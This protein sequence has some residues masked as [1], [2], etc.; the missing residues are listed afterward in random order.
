M[1]ALFE[2]L[3]QLRDKKLSSGA[4]RARKNDILLDDI[5]YSWTVVFWLCK[6]FFTIF[7]TSDVL[8]LDRNKS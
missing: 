8:Y 6:F 4:A 3:P 2:L 1:E 5:G 7:G